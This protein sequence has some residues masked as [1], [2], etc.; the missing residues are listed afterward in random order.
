MRVIIAGGRDFNDYNLLETKVVNIFKQLTDEGYLNG[1]IGID[2]KNI[3]IVSGMA[4]GTDTLGE[5]FASK[6]GIGIKHFPA[7]WNLLG[8]SAGY[9][10]NS[11]MAKYASEDDDLGILIAFWDGISKGTKHMI[12]LANKH[13]LRVFIVNY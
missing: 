2:N 8:K 5:K 10:R 1:N 6:V 3:E 4:R 11:E 7:N 9:R 12:D 13:G